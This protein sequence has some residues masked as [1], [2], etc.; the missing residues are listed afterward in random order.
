MNI[1]RRALTLFVFLVFPLTAFAQVSIN[2][3]LRGHVN[4][5]G[6]RRNLTGGKG[7]R[8]LSAHDR[9]V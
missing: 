6:E 1:R 4:D 5:T 2:G 7:T 9:L 3:S 8:L